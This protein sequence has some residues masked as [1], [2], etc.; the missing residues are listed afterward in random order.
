MT[1]ENSARRNID[2]MLE[3]VGWRIQNY[4]ERD[5]DA[6]FGVAVREYRL[7]AEQRADY[8]LFIG[9]VAVGVIEAK[10][11]GTTLSGALQQ[12]ERYR[13]SLPDDLPNR[14]R[15]SFPMPQQGLRHIFEIFETL[16]LVLDP[17]LHFIRLK[18]FLMPLK[19]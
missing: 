14:T 16:I 5:T 17:F 7:R 10:P 9:G 8:L 18:H 1:P 12:A 2:K 11:E 6:A 4:A 13:A 3:A 19:L 15:F